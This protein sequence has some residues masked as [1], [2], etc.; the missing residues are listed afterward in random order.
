MLIWIDLNSDQ[1]KKT[2]DEI[3]GKYGYNLKGRMF[4]Y[5]F[6]HG[7]VT[8]EE[9]NSTRRAWLVP[10]DAPDP[11][12]NEAKFYRLAVSMS[13]IV[14]KAKQALIKHAFFAFEACQAG[15]VIRSLSTMGNLEPPHIKGY[16]LSD[17]TQRPVKQFLTA[18][19]MLQRVPANN[20]FTALLAGALV[21]PA[22]DTNG[23]GF[24]TG[25]KI[26]S[27]VALQLPQWA[28]TYRQ[29][30]EVGNYP[31]VE[32]GDMVFGPTAS[33][34]PI[35]CYADEGDIVGTTGRDLDGAN[36][37]QSDMT[38]ERCVA[39]CPSRGFS[40]AATQFGK[41]CFCGRSY[42]KF[43]AAPNKCSTPCAGNEHEI[44]GGFWANSV[45]VRSGDLPNLPKFRRSTV[46]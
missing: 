40:Y 6:G 23:D 39:Y 38:T 41:W 4:F 36:L 16:V 32:G 42:G 7:E 27:Y 43:G 25:K 17:E 8:G 28:T 1:L 5:Y 24:I 21:D 15:Y 22:A 35:G 45:Y 11:I 9:D 34:S 26:M 12:E 29:Q 31:P 18:G 20:S 44:C 33:Y 19:N 30:P 10:V 37:E 14:E 46:K 2:I 13:E 3:F